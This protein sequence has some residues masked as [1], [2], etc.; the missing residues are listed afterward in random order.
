MSGI[1][2]DSNV[3]LDLLTNDPTWG[4]WSEQ[5]LERYSSIGALYIN[6]LI[7]TEVSVGFQRIETLD[8]VLQT[9]NFEH[10]PMPREA[11]FLAGKVFLQ[12]RRAGGV[13]TSP[14]PDFFIGAHAAV[15]EISLLTRDNNRYKT[16]FPTIELLTP[17]N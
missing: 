1:L 14:L 12:Y 11:L 17:K 16:Y 2:V 9:G 13:R 3:I 7:Y 5:I 6:D 4:D 10:L 8:Q 15:S